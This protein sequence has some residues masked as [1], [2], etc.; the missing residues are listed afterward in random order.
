M[1]V[2]PPNPNGTV[3]NHVLEPASNVV[4]ALVAVGENVITA[5]GV[6]APN[7]ELSTLPWLMKSVAPCEPRPLALNTLLNHTVEP[8]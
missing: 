5:S 7:A 6:A 8:G 4:A 3:V 2:L 1:N